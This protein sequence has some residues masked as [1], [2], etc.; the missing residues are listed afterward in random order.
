MSSTQHKKPSTKRSGSSRTK[1]KLAKPA[2]TTKA[3]VHKAESVRKQTIKPKTSAPG[4]Q[5]K[6]RTSGAGD[7]RATGDTEVRRTAAPTKNLQPAIAAPTHV[8]TFWSPMA[9]L[10]RQQTL[11][12]SM[13][14]HVMQSQRLWAQALM[15]SA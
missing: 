2:S 4:L 9:V 10:V 7:V 6:A 12:A 3:L 11:L 1:R 14:L 5:N 8:L 13:V 15:R